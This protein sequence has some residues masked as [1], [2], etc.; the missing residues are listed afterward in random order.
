ME[1][2]AHR[3]KTNVYID[4]FNLYYRALRGTPYKWLDLS[5]LCGLALPKNEIHRIRYFTALV[6][7]RAGDPS[8]LER[9]QVYLRALKTIPNLTVHRGHFLES[10]VSMRL[11]NPPTEGSP[12]VRC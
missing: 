9:Q 3:P 11:A 8:Q 12:Y 4:G 7:P 2:T 10:V 5:R 6:K 1:K